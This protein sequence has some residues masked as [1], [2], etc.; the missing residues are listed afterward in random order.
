[1]GH[2]L[3][4]ISRETSLSDKC[5]Q[6]LVDYI[7]QVQIGNNKMPP[8]EELA[9]MLGVSRTTVREAMRQLT[10]E[11]LLTRIPGQGHFAHRSVSELENRIDLLPDIYRLLNEYYG[12]AN[13]E[14]TDVSVRL[15]SKECRE[16]FEREEQ[17]VC[18]VHYMRWTYS[19]KGSP[20]FVSLLEFPVQYIKKPLENLESVNGL[21]E[22]STQYMEKMITHCT[23]T[24]SVC[25]RDEASQIL[26]TKDKCALKWNESIYNLDD[27]MV[28]F[29]KIYFSPDE[30]GLTINAALTRNMF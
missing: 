6:S 5:Y 11:G 16:H 7:E 19:A 27:L 8:E 2:R 12:N 30:I 3:K 21:P 1:M 25:E 24:L 15:P 22:L 18:K 10:A 28:G 23:M 29:A 17:N 9:A 20:K 14:I 26:G 13:L 4:R